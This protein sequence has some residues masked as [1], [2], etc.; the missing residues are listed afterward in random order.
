MTLIEDKD[1]KQSMSTGDVRS[2]KPD[3]AVV[4]INRCHH[5]IFHILSQEKRDIFFSS[6]GGC[7][8]M[9]VFLW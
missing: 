7:G 8:L 4:S 2:F 6:P 9:I 3:F 5:K 1:E